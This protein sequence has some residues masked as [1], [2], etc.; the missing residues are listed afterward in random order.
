MREG[1]YLFDVIRGERTG[2]IPDL[3]RVVLAV[4]SYAYSIGLKLFL[5]PFRLGIRRRT[6]VHVGNH[7]GVG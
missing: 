7:I 4:L 3:L 5:L 2:P 1:G 6:A